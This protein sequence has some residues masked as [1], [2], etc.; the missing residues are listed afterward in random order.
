GKPSELVE[1]AAHLRT[2]FADVERKWRRLLERVV[3]APGLVAESPEEVELARDLRR[4]PDVAGVGVAGHERQRPFLAAARDEERR[5]RAREALRQVQGAPEVDMLAVE[6]ALAAA[7][8]CPHLET[9]LDR[10]LEEVEPFACRL[11]ERQ[12]EPRCLLGIVARTE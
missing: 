11:R 3:V 5:V 10:L 9:G 12:P 6:V 2:V 1:E 4:R 8:A 7:I